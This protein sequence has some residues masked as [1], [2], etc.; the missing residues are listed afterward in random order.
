MI[1]AKPMLTYTVLYTYICH[2]CNVTLVSQKP[3]WSSGY[4]VGVQIQKSWVRIQSSQK[5]NFAK[6]NFKT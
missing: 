3:L 1:G 5:I 4:D 6:L 2:I